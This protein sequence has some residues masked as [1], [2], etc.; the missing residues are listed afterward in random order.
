MTF[1][2]FPWMLVIVKAL[3]IQVKWIVPFAIDFKLV[4]DFWNSS[5]GP[6]EISSAFL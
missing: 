4:L 6:N 2:S 5:L 3:G 1:K